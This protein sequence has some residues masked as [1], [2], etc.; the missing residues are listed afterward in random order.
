MNGYCNNV[1]PEVDSCSQGGTFKLD[2]LLNFHRVSNS[3]RIKYPA[4]ADRK[5]TA[6]VDLENVVFAVH[7]KVLHDHVKYDSAR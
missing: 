4:A 6:P 7:N 3:V 2:D 5:R 1:L